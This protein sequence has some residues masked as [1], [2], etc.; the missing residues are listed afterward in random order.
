MGLRDTKCEG[1][2]WIHL[3]QGRDQWRDLVNTVANLRDLYKSKK[4]LTT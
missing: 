3:A 2:D 4:L 1:V